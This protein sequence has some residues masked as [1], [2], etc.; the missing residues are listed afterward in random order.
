M[1]MSKES[2]ELWGA[3][4]RA[5]GS[6]D[7]L[8]SDMPTVLDV[9]ELA[10]QLNRVYD[11]PDALSTCSVETHVSSCSSVSDQCVATDPYQKIY[12]NIKSKQAA[13]ERRERK[14][15]AR[16]AGKK[17]TGSAIEMMPASHQAL[18]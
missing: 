11:D 12:P 13:K 14:K 10:R 1:A 8:T 5:R 16:A 4:R 7:S 2:S 15:R 3:S 17:L 9:F 6:S 18:L